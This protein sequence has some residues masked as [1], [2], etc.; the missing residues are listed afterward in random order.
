MNEIVPGAGGKAE[1]GVSL[2]DKYTA[3]EGKVFMNGTQALVRLPMV[4]MRRDRAAGLNTG[5]FISGYRGSPVG[6][7]DFALFQARRHLKAHDIHFQPGVNEDLAATAVWGSQN[8]QL[9]PGVTKD[10]VVGI[11]YGKGPGVDRCGDVFKHANS[12][13]TSPH[14]GV[15]AI[16]GDD[17]NAKSSTVAHQSDH[18]FM[19]AIMPMLFP[20]SVH[21]FVELG[22]LGIAMSRYAG[23]WVGY[24]VI[25]DTI[26]TT[27][28]VD[29]AGE[30]RQFLTP[31]DFEMPPTGLNIRWPDDRYAQDARLQEYKA[32]AAIAFARVNKVDQI[33]IDSRK[34]RFGIIASGKAYEN[35]RE[36]LRHMGID[37]KTAD[38]IG[39]RLYKVRMPWPLEP[40]G[41]RQFSEGLEEVLVIEER[42]EVIEHQIKQQL[43]NWR[44]DVRPRIVGKFD[45]KDRHIL[46]LHEEVTTGVAV[47]AIASRLLN[48]SLPADLKTRLESQLEHYQE[49]HRIRLEHKAPVTRTPHFC[50]G[51]PHNTSTKVPDGSRAMAG[52][53]CHFMALWM[54]RNTETYTHM[55]GEGVPWMGTAPFTTEKHVFANIGDGTYFHSGLMA[56][57][58]SVAAGNNITYKVLYNDAVAMT[59]GQHVDGQ[60]TV[61]Q[62]SHQLAAEGVKEIWLVSDEPDRY[63]THD[64]APGTK[65]RGREYLDE[66]QRQLREVEGCTAIIYDQTCAAEKRR[67]RKRGTMVDPDK[68]V[69]INPL[70]CEGCGD[71]SV[72]SNCIAVEPLETEFGRK[73]QINQ[74]ACNKDFS[75]VNGFC[76][77]FVTVEGGK[78]RKGSLPAL[79]S[80]ALPEPDV[81][82]L[83]DVYNV[84]IT[85]VGG[86]GVLTIG[87]I[88]GMAAHLDGKAAMIQ[89]FSGLAQKG[90]AVLSHVRLAPKP[91]M[92]ASAQIVT[93][94]A[95][96][97]I[98]AD[99]VVAASKDGVVLYGKDRTRAVLNTH[100][101]PVSNFVFNRDF[102]FREHDVID[103]IAKAMDAKPHQLD[104]GRLAEAVC[105][106]TIAT[107]IMM[108]GYASQMGLLP[109]SAASLLKA[110][111]LNGVS[112]AA[113][114]LAFGWGRRFAVH[115]GE[116]AQIL[117]A[118]HPSAKEAQTLEE[119]VARR[120]EFLT[121]YQDA[122]WAQRYRDLVAKAEAADA[123][124]GKRRE[125]SNAVARNFFKLMAYKDEYEVARLYTD[126][127][128][129]KRIRETFDGDFKLKF[130]LA[131][132]VLKGET[133]PNGRPRKKQF[134]PW[135]MPAFRVLAKLKFLRGTALDPF[136]RTAERR[137]ERRL[138]DDYEKMVG[139][140]AGALGEANYAH[141]VALARL[142]DVI[143]GYGPVKEA[144]VKKAE[145]EKADLIARF[146]N[147]VAQ[148]MGKAVKGSRRKPAEAAE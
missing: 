106:D 72:Q 6:G 146:R 29:L 117:E 19:A 1:K 104:F 107:N 74:S 21:E 94:E 64:L 5:A 24:K 69:F 25:S 136:G 121:A 70:V 85:G 15:L 17:H 138:I 71:C 86:T 61:P 55:G 26:E 76:P 108:L 110:I 32:Y 35:V 79:S 44:A 53:G 68:R 58:Q 112:I 135:M 65:V 50:A 126:G 116:A 57:R 118:L 9:S 51:C 142:P 133:L 130:H 39:L 30:Q 16:A 91:E 36:A 103:T 134:G 145:A 92:V 105:G 28:V 115:P 45:D 147:P 59:G 90:G 8:A 75:C 43:F 62:L 7:Y 46:S 139:E 14:G 96:V 93:G 97:L 23:L 89:D 80:E 47:R 127:D 140:I 124:L 87:A 12:F 49:R 100:L 143:R 54:N 102:D 66:V 4:Q 113:N 38:R 48:F 27:A 83:D 129:E 34:P 111:E 22:L 137:M 144:A 82:R 31:N 125:L 20:T 128:F 42:R 120:S 148:G 10:G 18:A 122:K 114:R 52:I 95:D 101:S 40:E 11:W 73:R 63:P 60:L 84:A 3:T 56:I 81:V 37:E 123:A 78:L 99:T 132:P 131:P 109:V 141:A 41:V 98:A 13:G 67:R 33:A 88:I 77:S 2:D 119:I